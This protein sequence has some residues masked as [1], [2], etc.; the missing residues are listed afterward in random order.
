MYAIIEADGRQYKVQEGDLVRMEIQKGYTEGDTVEFEKVLALLGEEKKIG[1]PY[2]ENAKV[3][4]KVEKM[5]KDKKVEVI[6]FRSKSHY[7]KHNGH[8]Q[9]FADV[10]IEKIG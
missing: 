3:T 6:K 2:V 7:R 5:G 4:G 9:L 10:R 1:Q 8:R